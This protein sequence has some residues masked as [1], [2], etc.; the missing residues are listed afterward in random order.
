MA[1]IGEN[2]AVGVNYSARVAKILKQDKLSRAE[3]SQLTK[4]ELAK[5]LC[6]P[7]FLVQWQVNAFGLAK[8]CQKELQKAI[9]LRAE[10]AKIA[11][12]L[13]QDTKTAQIVKVFTEELAQIEAENYEQRL[14]A[15]RSL[16][17]KLKAEK[18][19]LP[20][21]LAEKTAAVVVVLEELN[22]KNKAE[23]RAE[24]DTVK[25]KTVNTIKEVVEF[26]QKYSGLSEI[27]V[28]NKAQ[29]LAKIAKLESLNAELTKISAEIATPKWYQA[30]VEAAK[31]VAVAPPR[32]NVVTGARV[33]YYTVSARGNVRSSLAEFAQ[34]ANATLNDGRGWAKLGIRFEQVQSGGSFNLILSEAQL[35]PTF[36]SGCST[37]YSCRVG[38][39]VIIN[40][41]R[42][43][44]ASASWNGAGGGLNE[45]RQM[46][47]N[48][49][50]GH[51]LGHGH[52]SCKAAGAPAN[53]MQQQSIDMQGCQPNSWPLAEELFSPTLGI[54]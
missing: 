53:V 41:D 1:R 14:E 17:E 6:M 36:S 47:V 30:Q 46:V 35:L 11:E 33:V 4:E 21:Q 42:W 37:E 18:G 19:E 22:S 51:W 48:H 13:D 45:Y 38:V 28:E 32:T 12:Y 34:S 50:V 25:E 26:R 52:R 15:W 44:G 24:F 27:S 20:K 49:E 10:V 16:D 40:D 43:S 7:N 9:K 8:D 31:A 39:N 3:I 54:R 2:Q 5:D 29:V 23:N